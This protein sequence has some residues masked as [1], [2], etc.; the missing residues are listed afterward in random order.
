MFN[1]RFEELK[2]LDGLLDE[3][4]R[5]GQGV[6]V[7]VRGRRQVGKSRLV[8]EF[9]RR[10]EVPSLTYAAVRRQRADESLNEFSE[11]AQQFTSAAAHAAADGFRSW[12]QA[13][14]AT[15]ADHD[16]PLII[17]IDEF[18]WLI[19]ADATIE[20]RLQRSW[21]MVLSRRPVLVIL[22]GSDLAMMEA[23]TNH[24][25]PLYD[26]VRPMHVRP[27]DPSAVADITGASSTDAIEIMAITGGF[28]NVVV[29]WRDDDTVASFLRRE[30]SDPLSAL[31]VS[32]ERSVAAEFPDEAYARPVLD[33]IGHGEREFTAI[34]QRVNIGG[35]SLERAIEQLL[36][37][38]V[39]AKERA[40]SVATSKTTRYRVADPYMRFWLR[41]IGRNMAMI[42]RGSGQ[43]LAERVLGDW[44]R[45][46]GLAV[47]PIIREAVFRMIVADPAMS[48][49][50]E[51]ARWWRRDG[52]AEVDIVVGDRIG[53]ADRILA[54]GSIK[55]R[56]DRPFGVS[57]IA[58][59]YAARS[60]V[61]G[62]TDATLVIAATRTPIQQ[63]LTD[64]IDR[65]FRPDD[66]VNSYRAIS[67]N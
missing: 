66:L 21:D 57:D 42:E 11:L 8:E 38:R 61:P 63:G 23:L 43:A 50:A 22:V 1:G 55:W 32:G 18:P 60:I 27:L 26:R 3:V 65:I 12:A 45:W 15:S 67:A 7:A 31:I 36:D 64:E 48:D 2:A 19:E 35:S 33:A 59:L 4:R 14:E 29:R 37:K 5:R 28:P 53:V 56:N 10:S 41:Y 34:A 58:D 16:S 17:V 25:R 51:V 6:M 20:G 30:L 47:E 39:I 46:R 13:L 44:D 24:D 54:I 52:S 9:C 49:V 62:C 40:Y